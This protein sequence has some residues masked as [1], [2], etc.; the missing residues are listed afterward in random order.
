M[1]WDAECAVAFIGYL[2]PLNLPISLTRV[3]SIAISS[4][5]CG[6]MDTTV[7]ISKEWKMCTCSKW[8]KKRKQA[9]PFWRS[10]CILYVCVCQLVTNLIF[11]KSTLRTNINNWQRQMQLREPCEWMPHHRNEQTLNGICHTKYRGRIFVT[12]KYMPLDEFAFNGHILVF[13]I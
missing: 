6:E 7:T 8:E 12:N 10:G 4:L 1:N 3:F 2:F 11:S 5:C 9:I 13:P